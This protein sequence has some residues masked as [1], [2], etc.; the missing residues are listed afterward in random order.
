MSKKH[1]LI[2]AALSSGNYLFAQK[3]STVKQLDPVVITATKFPIK[4][5]QTGKVII[6]L[7]K[8]ELEKSIGKTLGQVLSEQAGLTIN[9][10]LN[11]MGTNQTIY[12]RG[13]GAGR[14]LI[15]IDGVPVNDPST[16]DNTF[17]INLIPLENIEQIEICKSAQSTLYGSD[18]VAGVIN[19]ITSK[20]LTSKPFNATASFAAG[21][22]GTYQGSLQ[23]YGKLAKKISYNIRYTRLS[24][25]GFSSAYDSTSKN[26]F[27]HDGYHEDVLTSNIAWSATENLTVKSFIQY[28]Q[29]KADLAQS[30]FTDATNYTSSTKNL[31]L[32]GGFVYKLSTTSI[33]GN[34]LYNTSSRLLLEDSTNTQTYLRDDY[35]GKTQFAELFA[36]SDLGYGFTLLNGADYRN[37]SMNETGVS[38][39]YQFGFSDTS[40]S[41]TSMYSS[42]FYSAKSGLN[43]ELGGRLNTHSRYGSNY[44]YSFNP[45]FIVNKNWKTYGSV[46]SGFKAPTL[47]QLYDSYSGNPKLNPEQSVNYEVGFQFSN[48]VMNMRVTYFARKI[49]NGLD[50]N[51]FTYRYFNYNKE[52]DH[53]VEWESK[54]HITDKIMLTANY[55]WLKAKEQS[56]SRI[57]YNDTTYQYALRRPEHTVNITLGAEP[58]KQI[59]ISVSGHYESRRYDIGGYDAYF[60]PLPDATLKSFFI[61]NAY[62]EYRLKGFLKFFIDGKNVFNRK[63]FTIYGYNS[64][65]ALL[66]AGGTIKL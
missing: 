22:Y 46:A 9:G 10:T 47:Y 13:A 53:G 36:S 32:G 19:I 63:F 29:N 8:T 34:Y 60:N 56:Q 44:T 2:V 62:A 25:D 11:N 64:I 5:S 61:V 1:F 17:D 41:Q 33:N 38:G 18:A 50:F 57:T 66:V 26:G 7:N 14:T 16:V 35:F 24:T 42:L 21:N 30:A 15:T 4:Q 40:V 48:S 3:D 20:P 12:M 28:G 45:S 59:Y 52:T 31:M 27:H 37:A 49:N 43:A 23:W 6:V 39:T 51:Y 54:I 58:M 65:P 55:T